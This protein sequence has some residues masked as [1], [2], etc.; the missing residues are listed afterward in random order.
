MKISITACFIPIYIPSLPR[1][2]KIDIENGRVR[3]NLYL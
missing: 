3:R 2:R 1:S